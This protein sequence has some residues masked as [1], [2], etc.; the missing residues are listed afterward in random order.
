MTLQ[1]GCEF[2]QNMAKF[3]CSAFD[4]LIYFYHIH[5]G[6]SAANYKIGKFKVMS[7]FYCI[8]IYNKHLSTTTKIENQ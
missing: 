4:L 7:M 6:Y 3:Q 1:L 2:V 5:E 8:G